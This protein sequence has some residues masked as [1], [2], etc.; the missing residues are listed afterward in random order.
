VTEEDYKRQIREMDWSDLR[1][2]WALIKQKKTPLWASGKALE[3]LI[4]RAFELDLATVRYPFSI[5]IDG[6]VTEQIDG[7]V[8]FQGLSC[9][10]EA[11]DYGREP[12][13]ND[14]NDIGDW[15]NVNFE[16]IAKLRSQLLRRPGATIGSIFTTS[17]FT[18]PALTLAKYLAPQTILLWEKSHLDVALQKGNI[19]SLLVQKYQW[20][21]ETGEPDL[22]VTLLP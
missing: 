12:D 2:L 7:V 14:P 9:L 11:K 18:S 22:D 1:E 3:Y 21:V 17:G 13:P 10:V 5:K 6:E 20:C 19:C 8:H 4:L 16:P 15:T